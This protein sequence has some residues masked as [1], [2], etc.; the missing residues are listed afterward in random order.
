MAKKKDFE[1]VV[2]A[3]GGMK[4]TELALAAARQGVLGVIDLQ[5][6]QDVTAVRKNLANKLPG[7]AGKVGLKISSCSSQEWLAL[8]LN[9]SKHLDTVILASPHTSLT[10][11]WARYLKRKKLDVLLEAVS[12]DEARIAEKT[13]LDGI[14]AKGNESGGFVSS[15]TTFILLQKFLSAFPVPIYAQGGI[16]Y[17][18]A[19]ACYVAGAE[20]VV[21]DWQL[22]AAAESALPES[23]KTL[24]ARM[25]GGETFTVGSKVS[26]GFR[27]Y[28][29]DKDRI[30]QELEK[31]ELEL[32]RV[33]DKEEKIRKWYEILVTVSARA[34]EAQLFA[35]GQD[36][37]LL[38]FG[39]KVPKSIADILRELRKAT[40][41]HCT[42]AVYMKRLGEGK[43]VSKTHG[44]RYPIVQGAMNRVSDV[45]EF[46]GCIAEEGA[47]PIM[48]IGAMEPYEI[49][50]MLKKTVSRLC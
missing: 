20:G 34:Q 49:D 23:V 22:A 24:V 44:T 19:A 14:I 37:G 17:H 18:T 30:R 32:S 26:C 39:K 7:C 27:L 47:L 16:G 43:G 3:P 8:V 29:G 25:D 36:T 4:N 42:T 10:A 35:A 46:A 31:K 9:L 48:A 45:P 33:A 13:G 28:A 15:D 50:D 1:Y 11:E 5:Y 40:V 12:A 2:I 21:L 6:E 38:S 41:E